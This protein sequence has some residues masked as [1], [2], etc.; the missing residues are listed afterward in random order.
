MKKIILA[1]RS[2]CLKYRIKLLEMSQR[3]SAIHLGGTFSSTEILDAIFNILMKKNER[4][5]F[6]FSKGHC[7]ALQYVILNCCTIIKDFI[8]DRLKG[9][10]TFLLVDLIIFITFWM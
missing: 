3:V 8:R 10:L 4:E 9:L 7:S 2:R 1:A 6:I 5:N